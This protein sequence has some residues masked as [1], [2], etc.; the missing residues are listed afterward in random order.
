M[1]NEHAE[2][3]IYNVEI[4]ENDENEKLCSAA[5]EAELQNFMIIKFMKK[6][7]LMVKL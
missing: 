1:K 2:E 7:N 6:L 5:K 4:C 3:E